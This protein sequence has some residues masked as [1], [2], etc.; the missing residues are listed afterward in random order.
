[1][2]KPICNR[3]DFKQR[4]MLL[5]AVDQESLDLKILPE[6]VAG[7]F[8]YDVLPNLLKICRE[9]PELHI[10]SVV[11]HTVLVN[12]CVP[13]ADYFFLAEGDNDPRLIF[14]PGLVVDALVLQS[15]NSTFKR[16]FP[17]LTLAA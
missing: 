11:D 12:R 7:L 17:N 1:M 14:D 9:N 2:W 16:R 6:T 15:L 10:V 5:D 3:R 8:N 4:V 13:G